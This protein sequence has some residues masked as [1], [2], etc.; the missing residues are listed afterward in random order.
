MSDSTPPSKKRVIH[1]GTTRRGS[2]Q[3]GSARRTPSQG[4]SGNSA[5]RRGPAKYSSRTYGQTKFGKPRKFGKPEK[6]GH[7]EASEGNHEN[8]GQSAPRKSFDDP[9]PRRRQRPERGYEARQNPRHGGPRHGSA[10][11]GSSRH[12]AP[13]H[14]APRSDYRPGNS[15]PITSRTNTPR[16][17]PSRTNLRTGGA[18]TSTAPKPVT[19]ARIKLRNFWIIDAVLRRDEDFGYYQYFVD[20]PSGIS[21]RISSI[22]SDHTR[23][24]G[25]LSAAERTKPLTLLVYPRFD[26]QATVGGDISS[27][28]STPVV[29][30]VNA[31]ALGGI[32]RG[33]H[34][35]PPSYLPKELQT[36]TGYFTAKFLEATPD[37]FGTFKI[38]KKEDA[39]KM[40]HL[41]FDLSQVT[42]PLQPEHWVDL[43]YT[44]E[45]SSEQ[46][47]I[48]IQDVVSQ[49]GNGAVS[50]WNDPCWTEPQ[51]ETE[52]EEVEEIQPQRKH[53]RRVE[54]P[55]KK[56]KFKYEV[57]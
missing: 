28:V 7:S 57:R 25:N 22:S 14:G 17:N 39:T 15:R 26:T 40:Q 2:A 20:L 37:G 49:E 55:I 1:V 23:L 4:G 10:S 51:P 42:E 54:R 34:D 38:A 27:S 50:G 24:Y 44:L 41:S 33:N 47:K 3:N 36:N 30:Q 18:A 48:V 13:R 5:T 16:T 32:Y 53:W 31:V 35:A 6:P 56:G 52:A 11:R 21:L 9:S 19:K 43:R 46:F 8:R 12:G 29:R 45:P